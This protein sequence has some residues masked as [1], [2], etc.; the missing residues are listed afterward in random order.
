MR[1]PN[2]IYEFLKHPSEI[3]TATQSSKLL[4]RSMA[5][6]INGSLHVVEFGAG[7][8]AVTGQILKRLPTNGRLTCFEINAQFC[9]QLLK[10]SDPRLRV[11][12]DDAKNCEK[13]IH[14]SECIVSGLPLA[15][16]SK[17]KRER[18]LAISSKSKR[19]IQI[20]YSPILT[21]TVK[22]YFS[23]VRIKFM[24]LNFPPAFVYVCANRDKIK[25][26]AMAALNVGK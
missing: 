13:Y 15:L 24:P 21:K 19:F 7:M 14:Y 25:S 20:Q 8:G 23:D 11:I 4:A 6:E 3:G 22:S 5:Q 1:F 10:I 2:F 9:K 17:S 18:I 16:F 26:Q 12:N